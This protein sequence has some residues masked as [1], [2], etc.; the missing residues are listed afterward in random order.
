MAAGYSLYESFVLGLW[1]ARLPLFRSC[2]VLV[3]GLKLLWEICTDINLVYYCKN[4]KK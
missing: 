4:V 1:E 3:L 2:N